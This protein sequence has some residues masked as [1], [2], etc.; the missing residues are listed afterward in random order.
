MRSLAASTSTWPA[1]R[2]ALTTGHIVPIALFLAQQDV[3]TGVTGRCFD[4]MTWNR[5]HGLGT[6]KDWEDPDSAPV[7]ENATSGHAS[8][9]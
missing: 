7:A 1:S 4:T 3:S 8:G 6:E 2:S 5:E 9:S